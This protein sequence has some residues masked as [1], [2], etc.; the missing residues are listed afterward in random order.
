MVGW[1]PRL[2]A[3]CLLGPTRCLLPLGIFHPP[4]PKVSGTGALHRQPLTNAPFFPGVISGLGWLDR[5]LSLFSVIA[6]ILGVVIGEF[7]PNAKEMLSK[8]NL[9][10]TSAP[11]AVG[12]IVMM[13]PILTKVRGLDRTGSEAV[14]TLFH[15]QVQ[16]E[17]LPL[18]LKTRRLWAQIGLSL[19]INWIF[20]PFLMLGLAWATLPDLEE[21]RIGIIMVGLA[22]C[23]AMVMIWN[24]IARG[25]ANICAIIVIINSL[26]QIVLYAPMSLLFINVISGSSDFELNYSD[27][28][29]SVVIVSRTLVDTNVC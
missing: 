5:L 28:A 21:Y 16:Y 27:T 13:W 19:V 11:L 1:Y 22:R 10:G 3:V 7:A 23:I 26:L 2:M 8:G 24:Q 14:L 18:L 12:L 29:I 25:D 6:M 17:Q 20:G 4:Q 9:K 15:L